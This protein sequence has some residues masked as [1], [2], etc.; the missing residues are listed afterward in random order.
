MKSTSPA[1]LILATSLR[2]PH[3]ATAEAL[4]GAIAEE[5]T[6]IDLDPD[7]LDS[8]GFPIMAARS[9]DAVDEALQDEIAEWLSSAGLSTLRLSDEQWRALI[10]GTGVARELA[11]HAASLLLHRDSTPPLLKLIPVLP[12]DWQAEQ[13]NAVN[14]WFEHLVLQFGWPAAHLSIASLPIATE[15]ASPAAF[16]Q[17]AQDISSSATPVAALVIVCASN[18]GQETVDQWA[19]RAMLFTASR[20]QGRVP[21]EGAAGMLL[22]SPDSLS[23]EMEEFSMLRLETRDQKEA[24]SLEAMTKKVLDNAALHIADIAMVVADT[25]IHN[26][27]VLEL[28]QF[29]TV[30]MPQLD[31]ATD[32]VRVGAISGC[33]GD[34]PFLASLALAHHYACESKG[35]VLVIGNEDPHHACA[36]LVHAPVSPAPAPRVATAD[37]LDAPA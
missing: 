20:P 22:T 15:E 27:R 28:M 7:L 25:G 29:A 18:I 5:K 36:S 1:L 35:P 12:S 34:V 19:A 26:K 31:G 8:D 16:D 13:R 33:C 24:V 32:V 3:G 2:L 4:A 11:A 17:L 10:L 9:Q 21:G 30:S 6:N 23:A 37:M 14:K